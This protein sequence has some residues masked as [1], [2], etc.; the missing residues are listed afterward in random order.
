MGNFFQKTASAVSMTALVFSAMGATLTSASSEF[1][2]YARALV[3]AKVINAQTSEA[4]FRLNDNITRAEL[5]KVAANLGGFTSVACTGNVYTDV[6]A[7]LGDLCDAIETLA[8]ARVV[9]T[10]NQRFRPLDN[11]TR[12]EMTKMLLAATG[13]TP[14]ATSAGY[15]DVTSALGDLEGY[16]NRANEI[17]AVASATNFR[18]NATGT[19]GEVFK[20]AA[21]VANLPIQDN[22]NTPTPTPTPGTG[23]LTAVASGV[24]PV[25]HVPR[26]ASSVKVGTV[27]IRATGGDATLQ[28]LSI[29]RSGLGNP[30]DIE[31]SNGIRAAIEGKIVSSNGDYYN[32]SSQQGNIFFAPALTLKNGESRKIDI[33]VSLTDTADSNSQHQFSVTSL[34]GKSITPV[35]LGGMATTGYTTGK[36]EAR[37][38]NKASELKPGTTD[39]RVISVRIQP[40]DRDVKLAGFAIARDNTTQGSVTRPS[41]D[42][43]RSLANIKVTHN[44][45]AVGTATVAADKIFVTG[46][47]QDIRVGNVAV[48]EVRADV[49]LDGVNNGLSLKLEDSSDVT[50]TEITTGQV[51]RVVPTTTAETIAFANVNNSFVNNRSSKLTVAPGTYNVNFFD[52][53][54]TSSVPLIVKKLKVTPVRLDGSTNANFPTNNPLRVKVNGLEVKQITTPALNVA[55]EFTTTFVVDENT[56]ANIT[57]ESNVHDNANHGTVRFKVELVEVTDMARNNATLQTRAREGYDV[58]ISA[59]TVNTYGSTARPVNSIAANETVE[60]GSFGLASRGQDIKVKVLGFDVFDTDLPSLSDIVDTSNT[61]NIQVYVGDTANVEQA[62][63]INGTVTVTGNKIK[64]VPSNEYYM[65]QDTR[66]HFFLKIRTK[67]FASA[68]YEKKL[69]YQL[70]TAVTEVYAQSVD[71]SNPANKI[72]TLSAVKLSSKVYT[73]GIKS[74]IIRAT[75]RIVGNN[76]AEIAVE[77]NDSDKDMRVKG[78]KVAITARGADANFQNAVVKIKDGP[79]GTA[80]AA[81]PGGA[82]NGAE[83]VFD[84][85]AIMNELSSPGGEQTFFVELSG[86]VSTDTVVVTVTEITYEYNKDDRVFGST[87]TIG[88]TTETRSVVAQ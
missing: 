74:P 5:A 27:E 1:L 18:P 46:I 28:S 14:S 87:P 30:Q 3:D 72:T 77:N 9:T 40:T 84:T 71:S 17:G 41:N 6:K 57:I 7:N 4:G 42:L 75:K 82:V 31:S 39:Q 26:N 66:K 64:F 36:V 80:V 12:A 21:R 69:G 20:I 47:N 49:L 48:F 51:V 59:G 23:G 81:A 37:L 76:I 32:Y 56:P 79:D 86:V 45:T 15:A 61:D 63:E 67:D 62:S 24:P 11:V 29:T 78:L 35:V 83:F 70:D 55:S 60:M 85:T 50:A 73:V 88:T 53:K 10:A 16:I 19:R 13:N 25:Q 44:G 34:N 68:A 33:L 8:E 38:T 43:T 2:P 22:N 52:A 54:L 58:E 65:S